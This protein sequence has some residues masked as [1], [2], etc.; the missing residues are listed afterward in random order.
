MIAHAI[1]KLYLR[2][3]GYPG[4]GY[5]HPQFIDSNMLFV[6]FS[7]KATMPFRRG[8]VRLHF[9]T[10][11]CALCLSLLKLQI[12]ITI[13]SVIFP[14]IFCVY[15]KIHTCSLEQQ[16]HILHSNTPFYSANNA[17]S[18]AVLHD[19]IVCS[20]IFFSNTYSRSC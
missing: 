2:Y 10:F 1:Q 16:S 12:I 5:H 11:W 14:M 19:M 8:N 9:H 13:D 3:R 15:I 20:F 4:G 17:K 18:N 7:Q 6:Q